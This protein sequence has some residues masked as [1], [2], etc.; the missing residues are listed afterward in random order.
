M[1]YLTKLFTLLLTYSFIVTNPALAQDDPQLQDSKPVMVIHPQKDKEPG[2]EGLGEVFNASDGSSEQYVYCSW[3][4][5]Q[6]CLFGADLSIKLYRDGVLIYSYTYPATTFGLGWNHGY[7]DYVG[8][9]KSHTYKLD[10]FSSDR[11]LCN[12]HWQPTNTGSTSPLKPPINVSITNATSSDKYINMSWQNGSTLTSYYIIYDDGVAIATTTSTSYTVST[13]P[14]NSSVWGVAT[15]SNY[16]GGHTSSRVQ[17]RRDTAPFK[18][19]ENFFASSDTTVGYVRLGWTCDSD[20]ATQFQI[21]RDDLLYTTIPVAQKAYLDYDIFPGQQYKYYVRSYTAPLYSANS[22][23]QF[24]RSVF[25]SASDGT[26]EDE[27]Y[28]YWTDFPDNPVFEDE[29]VLYRD[30]VPVEGVFPDQTEKYDRL[31]D[32]GK[33]HKYSL[34]VKKENNVRLIVNDHGFAPADG[35]VKG[36]VTT[37]TGSGVKNVEMKAY[38]TSDNLSS[39]LN[40]DGVDDFI[41]ASPLY[42]NSNT[43]TL[44]AWIKRNGAQDDWDGLI[45]SRTTGSASGLH[46]MGNGELRY[47]WDNLSD[48]YNW[49]SGLMVPDNEWTFIALII[50]PNQATLFVNDT[51]AV[52]TL[53]H[54]EVALDGVLEIGR[55]WYQNARYFN[56]SIDEICIWNTARTPEQIMAEQHHILRGNETG[57]IAYWRFNIGSG[58]VAGDYANN[59]NHHATL[60]G[61]PAWSD[62]SPQVWHYGGTKTNGSYSISRISWEEDVDFTIRPYKPGHGFKGSN[63]PEDS[64]ILP[65]SADDHQYENV[66]FIDT[67]SI[68]V[69]GW[70]FLDTDSLCPVPGVKILVDDLSSG[71]YTDTTGHFSIS[72]AEAGIYTISTEFLNHLFVPEDTTLDVQDPVTDLLFLDTTMTTIAG[73]VAGGCDNF[74]G[75]ADIQI[76]SLVSSCLD[77]ILQT[78]VNGMYE[79][80]LPAQ[81]YTVQLVEI[82]HPDRLTIINY[83][84]LDTVDISTHDTTFNLTYHSP[85]ILRF[86]ELPAEGCGNYDVPI[87]EQE[88]TWALR[89]DVV[90]QYGELEC[91]VST[92]TVKLIDY[93][94]YSNPD[95]VMSLEDGGIY[96]PLRPGYPNLSGGGVR[97]HQKMLVAK[98]DVDKYT[99]YDTLWVFVRGQKPREFQFSTVSPEIPLLIL[100]DPPG[101]Q[102]YSYLSR[103]TT[104]SINLGFSFESEVSVGVFTTFKV[105]GGG[106]IPG[107]GSTGAWV[108]GNAEATVGVRSTL[109]GSTELIIS[110]KEMIKTS[111]SDVITGS[112][113]D[114]YMGAALNIIY[115]KTDILDYNS[116]TCA[117]VRDTGIAWNGDGFKTTY[118]YTESHIRESVIP[119]LQSIADI[120]NSSGDP[121]K[122][123]SAEVILNQID[124]WQQV[125]DYNAG[126]KQ[127]AVPIPQFPDNVSFSAGPMLSEEATI[128]STNSLSVSLALFIDASVALSVGAKVGDFNEAEAGVKI[129]AKLELGVS[130]TLT[131]SVEN[132]IGFELGD[133]DEDPPGDAFT[134]NIKGDPVYGTPVFE[135]LSGTSSCPWEHPTLP[136]EGVG[137]TMNTFELNNVPP[138]VPAQFALYLYNLT[139]NNESRTYLLSMI[140]GSNPDGAIVSIAGAV[141]GDDQLSFPMGPDRDTPLQQTL[142]VQRETGSVY[143][144]ENLQV[145]LYSPCD[146][147]FDTTVSFSVHFIKPCSDVNIVTP[148]NNWILNQSHNSEMDIILKDYDALDQSMIEL[149]CEYR[150]R[151]ANDWTELFSYA[152]TLL[153]ADSIHRVWDM[154]SLAEGIYELRASTHCAIGTYYTRTHAGVYDK[155]A[156]VAFGHPQPADGSLD[157]G[158]DIKIEFSETID[159]VTANTD[160]ITM[161]NIDKN[162][163]VEIN[164]VC[165][166]DELVITAKNEADLTEGDSMRVTIQNLADPFGNVISEPITWAFVVNV[167]TLIPDDN[168]PQIPTQFS[169]DQNYP[170]PFNPVTTIRFAIPKTETVELAIFNVK[171]QMIM[172]PV[173]ERLGPGYYNVQVDGSTMSSGMYFYRIHA[174]EFVQTKKLILLK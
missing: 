64:L 42:L 86:S 3:T 14:G 79:I 139:Q 165:K 98:T 161:R 102:S 20:Y 125:L 133:D 122:E 169:L 34:E 21:Y 151:D 40:F 73:T 61:N 54:T 44:S 67:T 77:T 55:D 142:R 152:R 17:Q 76:R 4:I 149:K 154:S 75:V 132:T 71:E 65:F 89:I 80:T 158:D 37:P 166:G 11:L 148:R 57:L 39:A 160:N 96:Y 66:N 83:F 126:L 119:G 124:V 172:R 60:N 15:Y 157:I 82:D 31:V 51:S 106:D 6:Q 109:E 68:E 156:P 22:E 121:L 41:S 95:S 140:Q 168:E 112:D 174:G 103:A 138:E 74:L 26:Y 167:V 127:T 164:I 48:T 16:Y 135:L 50:E 118:L 143:D 171:G 46:I 101:D 35:S 88:K 114:V 84:T 108:G 145:H 58:T 8:P 134:V 38:A 45:Y 19:P 63:F 123:D 10:R 111:D 62:D 105:G 170:N 12:N 97:P 87:L 162:I 7:Y 100:R 33:I 137:L 93:V 36:S 117:A 49:S 155:T 91:P 113:G 53:A 131:H 153:P 78:D 104:T 129:S 72:V 1:R 9:N 23:T 163:D 29:L 128:T 2:P 110:A 85:P 116:G 47:N 5:Y 90:E 150:E 70:V 27:V 107:V 81:A 159:C 59:G 28:L 141:I 13:T 173:S 24:G 43:V 52:N 94:A 18:R 69:S 25:L 115:A 144:Y 136:R 147:Q 56:G 32:P 146:A 92:G 30:G 130:A 120:L 99:I